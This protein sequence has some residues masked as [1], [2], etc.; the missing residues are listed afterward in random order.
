MGLE[1][2][3]NF[4]SVLHLLNFGSGFR[5]QLHAAVDM[6]ANDTVHRGMIGIRLG[7]H[8]LNAEGLL[9]FSPEIIE[10][11]FGIKA[12]TMKALP[13]YPAEISSEGPLH[14]FV[15]GLVGAA[16]STGEA[17]KLQRKRSLGEFVLDVLEAHPCSAAALVT[18]LVERLPG[19]ADVA[20]YTHKMPED[21][22][23][24]SAGHGL[25]AAFYK[26]AQ[27]LALAL[28]RRFKKEQPRL[29]EFRDIAELT[30]GADNVLPAVLREL[31]VI[32][33]D[34][35]VAQAIT[36]NR[37]LSRNAEIALRAVAVD[38]CEKIVA[39]VRNA[40]G[41]LMPCEL[42]AY[43]WGTLGKQERFRKLERH[44]RK[45]TIFY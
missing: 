3:V 39:A 24:T 16:K 26:K 7:G 13:G 23:G 25:D 17:L 28:W 40:G 22:A 5:A 19:F 11:S 21:G 44:V 10:N 42:D 4:L 38:A 2:E 36:E 31:G 32:S 41:E 15:H 12:S 14:G 6:G 30:V 37:P 20:V 27:M 1:D 35:S 34:E 9:K 45:D 18:A 43:L 33:V 29:F 8:A